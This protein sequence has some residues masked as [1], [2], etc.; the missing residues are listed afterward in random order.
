MPVQAR[1]VVGTALNPFDTEGGR[2]QQG[3]QYGGPKLATTPSVR[4]NGGRRIPFFLLFVAKRA[5]FIH[6][7]KIYA[8]VFFFFMVLSSF[9][10]YRNWLFD[11]NEMLVTT[12]FSLDT[13]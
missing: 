11:K 4:T 10:F 6:T 5:L 9:S 8:G 12:M 3:V 7:V 2:G 1:P 13:R